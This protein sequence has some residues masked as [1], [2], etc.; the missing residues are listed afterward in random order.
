MESIKQEILELRK[1]VVTL[2]AGMEH[3]TALVEALVAAQVNP[4]M[5]EERMAK[6][7]L[8]TL[9]SFF[10]KGTVVSTPADFHREVDMKALL[11]KDVRKECLF[12]EGNSAG[13]VKKFGNDFSKKRIRGGNN[14]HQHHH[15][16]YIIPV[17]NSIHATPDYQQST[18]QQAPP[19]N[20]QNQSRKPNFDPIPMTYTE[21]FPALIHKNLVQTRSPP[22]IPE[23][24]PWWY[25]ADVTCAFHQDAPGHSL[26]DCWA[27][28]VEVQRLTRAGIL[29]FRDI[30]PDVQANSL[31]KH[32]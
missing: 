22:P 23:K 16:S 27:L 9:N 12:E 3:L 18:R 28:K 29:S 7:F 14:H 1:E 17:S 32:E 11:E 30:G 26:E 10:P 4:P 2:K 13:S 6:V 19:L 21:L 15:V 8:E 20:E 24:I 25:N 5:M 31:P